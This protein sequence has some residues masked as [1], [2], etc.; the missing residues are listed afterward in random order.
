MCGEGVYTYMGWTW[1]LVTWAFHGPWT[2]YLSQNEHVNAVFT[3]SGRSYDPHTNPNNPQDDY[4]TLIN[5]VSDDE[6]E[7]STPTPQPKT[8]KP[9]EAPTPKPY[10]PRIPY[11]QC[12]RKE[13]MEAQYEKFIDM[14]SL[15]IGIN[16]PL[17]QH[18][19]RNANLRQIS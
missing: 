11:P 6:N 14:I 13:K 16:V 8:P 3:R 9:K 19:S 15:S 5:F 2:S 12:L 1:A 4:E 18:I 17:D 10:K 7:E